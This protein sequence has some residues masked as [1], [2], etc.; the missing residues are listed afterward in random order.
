MGRATLKEV[1]ARKA[2]PCRE[3]KECPGIKPGQTYWLLSA[4]RRTARY[5]A[6]HK[7]SDERVRHFAPQSRSDRASEQA[8]QYRNAG[9]QLDDIK[10]EID[11]I[12]GEE[13]TEMENDKPAPLTA[14]QTTQLTELKGRLESV[15]VDT[16]ELESLA[17]E[18]RS[19]ADNMEES[20][21]STSKYEEVDE[22]ASNLENVD[23]EV[24][25]P[26]FPDTVTRETM[27]SLAE[28]CE[29]ASGS[30]EEKADEIGGIEFPG[31]Y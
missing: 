10:S 29:E 21:G 31:M 2:Y 27:E 3:S 23:A 11:D 8:D 13:P 4:F 6:N 18:M 24:D 14:D 26:S 30:C 17:E 15:D 7:P 25:M 22:C 20:F 12:L 16:S 9:S 28:E 1:K 5:C 19:W